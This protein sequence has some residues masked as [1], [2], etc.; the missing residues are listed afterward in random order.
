MHIVNRKEACLFAMRGLLCAPGLLQ[1]SPTR[2]CYSSVYVRVWLE[3][4]SGRQ[5]STQWFTCTLMSCIGWNLF[6][7]C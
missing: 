7:P 2:R 6:C 1:G 4:D 3:V 5:V